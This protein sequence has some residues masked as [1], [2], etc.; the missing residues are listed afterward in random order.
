MD[1]P[2]ANLRSRRVSYTLVVGAAVAVLLVGLVVIYG[3]GSSNDDDTATRLTVPSTGSGTEPS[4]TSVGSTASTAED[5]ATTVPTGGATD[6]GVTEDSITVVIFVA[7]TGGFT[8][9]GS[10]VQVAD[11]ETAWRVFY[12]DINARGGIAGRTVDYHFVPFDILDTDSMRA[13]CIKATED[14]GAFAITTA[15]KP[16]G[17]ALSC[18]VNEHETPTL[19]EGQFTE[20]VLAEA[21]GRLW[22]VSMSIDREVRNQMADL[23]EYGFLEDAVVGVID[24]ERSALATETGY[25]G[26]LQSLGYE[27]CGSPATAPC[28]VYRT[29][30]STAD[31]GVLSAEANEAADTMQA[32]GVDRLILHHAVFGVGAVCS[33]AENRQWRPQIFA[34]QLTASVLEDIPGTCA[35]NV[36]DGAIGITSQWTGERPA[37][38]EPRPGAVDCASRYEELTG[39]TLDPYEPGTGPAWGLVVLSCVHIDQFAA[40]VEAI[41]PD[42]TRERLIDELGQIGEI[43]G[44]VAFQGTWGPVKHDAA[45]F[46]RTVEFDATGCTCWTFIDPEPRPARD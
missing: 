19:A 13:A 16:L 45:D 22:T 3:F 27:E 17:P 36:A 21:E 28:Y 31:L 2:V 44:S 38:A 20:E 1:Q 12:D 32:A 9:A 33:A 23:E 46:V 18:V 30:S 6:V 14:I 11:Q 4:A 42:L 7:H 43:P 37:R 39:E 25:V 26:A 8:D 41:G 35:P 5:A 15:A 34:S 29:L 40:A 24:Y 10:D